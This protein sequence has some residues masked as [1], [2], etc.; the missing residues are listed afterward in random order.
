M[1]Q[2]SIKYFLIIITAMYIL[3]CGK[4]E[5]VANKVISGKAYYKNRFASD[6]ST[7]KPLPGQEIFVKMPGNSDDNYSY[8]VVTD[9]NGNFYIDASIIPAVVFTKGIREVG[10]GLMASFYGKYD[11]NGTET[12]ITIVMEVDNSKQNGFVLNLK[13]EAG[14]VMANTKMRI[15][16]SLLLAALNDP[17]GAIDSLVSDSRGQVF[18]TNIAAG[19]YYM[20]ASKKFDTVT[21]Q[22]LLKQVAVPAIGFIQDTMVLKK[23]GSQFQNGFTITAKDTLNGNVQGARMYLYSSQVFASNND[24]TGA[25]QIFTSDVN[26]KINKNDLPA[27]IYYLN[28]IRTIDTVVYQRLLKQLVVPASGFL[29]DT[30]VLRKKITTPQ[31]GFTIVV[32]DSLGGNIPGA[33]IY[34]YNSQV[35]ASSNDPAG[36]IEISKTDVNGIYFKINIPSGNYYLNATKKVDTITYQRLVKLVFVPSS[37]ITS[38]TM[39]VRRKQ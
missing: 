27:G 34:L 9:N 11:L 4:D 3:G 28:A 6:S 18:K 16:N 21:Y 17:S 10:T 39:I 24:S 20:N 30:I 37:G 13:D 25:V 8:K 26:G 36:A 15:Y 29:L 7:L 14:G 5:P 1:K 38:D 2:L 35:L 19:N 31:N 22:R 12:N 32:K 23:L 33:D